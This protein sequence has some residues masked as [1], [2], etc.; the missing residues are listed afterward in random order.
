MLTNFDIEEICKSLQLPLVGVFSKDELPKKN[1]IGSYYINME[2][3][4]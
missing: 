1:Y 2:N 4:D 3:H